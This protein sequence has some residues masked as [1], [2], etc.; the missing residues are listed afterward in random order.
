MSQH[1][2]TVGEVALQSSEVHI[3]IY[4]HIGASFQKETFGI[5][6]WEQLGFYYILHI[7]LQSTFHFDFR[8]VKNYSYLL[9]CLV[10]GFPCIFFMLS[11]LFSKISALYVSRS[12]LATSLCCFW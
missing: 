2:T 3:P 12:T 6:L 10:L 11:K 5:G 9:L 4:Y 8:S 1:A 7:L